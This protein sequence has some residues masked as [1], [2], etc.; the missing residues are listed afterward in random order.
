L[1]KKRILNQNQTDIGIFVIVNDNTVHV[2]K[3][4]IDFNNTGSIYRGVIKKD[5]RLFS[6]INERNIERK[7]NLTISSIY[8]SSLF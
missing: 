3:N 7:T 2:F 5:V 8:R 6:R 4:S 1:F